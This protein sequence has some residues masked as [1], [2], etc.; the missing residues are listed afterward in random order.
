MH[1]LKLRTHNYRQPAAPIVERTPAQQQAIAE[2]GT[3]ALQILSIG[4][5]SGLCC[6]AGSL[7]LLATFP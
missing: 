6:Y 1:S 4:L 2:T 7:L 3:A 5:L